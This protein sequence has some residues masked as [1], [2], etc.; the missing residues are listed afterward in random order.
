MQ[1]ANFSVWLITAGLVMGALATIAGVADYLANRRTR[2]PGRGRVHALGNA[3]VMLLSLVN[4]LIHSRDGY[5]SVVPAGIVLSAA[6][7]FLVLVMSWIGTSLTLR[8]HS[9][10]AK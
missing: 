3:L 6:V 1:W 4:V 10:L 5:T 7:A 9:E 2:T 8:F